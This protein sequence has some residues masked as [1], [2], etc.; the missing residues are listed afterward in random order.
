M[1]TG[2]NLTFKRSVNSTNEKPI[3][4]M[5]ELLVIRRAKRLSDESEVDSID[6]LICA[7]ESPIRMRDQ[8]SETR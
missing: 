8:L 2:P 4:Y 3:V 5:A 6:S 1:S 7:Y